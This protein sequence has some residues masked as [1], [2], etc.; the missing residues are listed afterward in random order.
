MQCG[1]SEAAE[2]ADQT[3][4]NNHQQE[5]RA[6]ELDKEEPH[7]VDLLVAKCTLV[8]HSVQRV[9]LAPDPAND[10][11]G[12]EGDQRIGKD[13]D[14]V[15]V[16]AE[17]VLTEDPDVAPDTEAQT[18]GDTEQQ[19]E[20]TTEDG[21][22]GAVEGLRVG[23]GHERDEDLQ[24]GDG[25]SQG[26]EEQQH[27]EQEAEEAARGELRKQ[28]RHGDEEQGRAG[29]DVDV[30]GEGAGDDDQTSEEGH[31]EVSES[32]LHRGFEHVLVVTQV[33]AV[34]DHAGGA[35][36]Q[37]EE[38]LTD[39][40]GDD[41][42]RDLGKV[43]L[44]V[45]DDAFA[46]TGQ[47]N[48][49]ENQD[50]QDD[51]QRRHHDLA[52]FLDALLDAAADDDDRHGEEDEG[53]ED[54]P[55]DVADKSAEEAADSVR[56]NVREC[57]EG[58]DDVVEHPAAEHRVIG[59]GKQ[60]AENAQVAHPGEVVV[61]EELAIG[62]NGV[63]LAV[64]ADEEVAEQHADTDD[65]HHDDV[66]EQECC[67]AVLSRHPRELHDVAEADCGARR[68]EN[69]AQTPGPLLT[70]FLVVHDVPP[71]FLLFRLSTAVFRL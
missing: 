35:D 21:G 49:A 70:G 32:D 11:G 33:A 39:S 41:R 64:T 34:V 1:K 5:D 37:R 10:N 47:G 16:Q 23:L 53:A 43:G 9:L 29:A 6:D 58:V 60:R 24:N 19:A 63:G 42:E 25:R 65:Q 36:V 30:E 61:A 3:G 7:I 56:R 2:E 57:G 18:D 20:H 15:V 8:G 62:R 28:G 55:P 14:E 54:R 71:Y 67:A 12:A 68:S 4:D 27:E 69:E 50:D 52:G 44:E 26:S 45:V 48:S 22:L 38:A 31:T 13:A 40:G 46:C 66:G 17:D 59:E 51:D